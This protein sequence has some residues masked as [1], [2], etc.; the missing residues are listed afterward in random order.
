MTSLRGT[1]AAVLFAGTAAVIA[2]PLGCLPTPPEVPSAAAMPKA[3][4]PQAPEIPTFEP[5]PMPELAAPDA[6]DV[7]LP[8]GQGGGNCCIRKGVLLESK[9]NGASSCCVKSLESQGD[10]EDADGFWFFTEEGCA[11]AC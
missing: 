6:P 10:C 2:A 9:C 5:P 3:E 7:P 11:G 4:I 8:P 1:L